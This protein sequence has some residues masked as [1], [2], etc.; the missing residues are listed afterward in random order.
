MARAMTQ[1]DR[2]LPG[3]HARCGFENTAEW[4]RCVLGMFR[5]R[6]EARAAAPRF[7]NLTVVEAS[8]VAHRFQTAAF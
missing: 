2:A 6:I 3:Y 1:S 8:I 7:H 5:R 4:C